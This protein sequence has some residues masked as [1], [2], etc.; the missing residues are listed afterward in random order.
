[1]NLTP[2]LKVACYELQMHNLDEDQ[3]EDI[4]QC[5]ECMEDML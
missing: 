4:R 5:A 1:M 3:F 2:D